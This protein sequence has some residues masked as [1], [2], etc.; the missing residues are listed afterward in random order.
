MGKLL[1]M[2]RVLAVFLTVFSHYFDMAEDG[3]SMG[4]RK[5]KRGGERERGNNT[6]GSDSDNSS[7]SNNNNSNEEFKNERLSEEELAEVK[8]VKLLGMTTYDGSSSMTVF[9]SSG[10][11]ATAISL[12]HCVL[13]GAKM[14]HGGASIL[15]GTSNSNGS[16][17]NHVVG[18]NARKGKKGDNKGG[19]KGG[20]GA[21]ATTVGNPTV[22]LYGGV[23]IRGFVERE[24]ALRLGVVYGIDVMAYEL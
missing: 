14:G 16:G 13:A 3:S 23:K 4:G 15:G 7:D 12:G 24:E 9:G 20:K 17:I 22:D 11:L 8:A 5:K 21:T 1:V 2:E 6:N 18:L 19:G 10:L